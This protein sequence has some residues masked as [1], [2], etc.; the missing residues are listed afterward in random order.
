MN[1]QQLLALRWARYLAEF[2]ART[3]GITAASLLVATSS[4]GQASLAEQPV[5]RERNAVNPLA[6]TSGT[7]SPLGVADG[8][9]VEEN[10]LPKTL[11]SETMG[12][13]TRQDVGVNEIGSQIQPQLSTSAQDLL[14]LPS[15][16]LVNSLNHEAMVAPLMIGRQP[17]VAEPNSFFLGFGLTLPPPTALQGPARPVIVRPASNE[18]RGISGGIRFGF[19]NLGGNDQV[20]TLG[21]E[22]GES[23]L[24]FDLDFRQFLED[25]SGYAVNFANRRGVAPEF[26]G[27]SIDVDPPNGGDPWVHR[28]GG[29]IEYFRPLA[30]DWDGALGISY[31]RVS[32]R[33]DLFTSELVAQDELGNPLTVSDD[34]QDDLLTLNFAAAFDQR[35]DPLFP[36]A[37]SRLLFGMDQA[38]PFG[39]ANLFYT[40]LSANYT[41]FIPLNLF[42]LTAGPQTLVLNI[43][44]GTI[45][46]DTPPYEAFSLGGASSVRGYR[47]GAVGTGRSFIQTTAEYRFPIF[48][49]NAF[50]EE[51]DIGGTLFFDYATDLGSGAAVIGT[52]GVVRNK[53]GDGFG[54]GFGVRGRTPFG[55][56]RLEFGITDEGDTRVIFNIGDRF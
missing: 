16:S 37:G 6:E 18:A 52:P 39:D 28:F 10:V 44:G 9:T 41:Q 36:T 12:L 54:Y 1:T 15:L 2:L 53:P 19:L 46:G 20:L 29:G 34:G 4:W 22:G 51:I 8:M 30:R 24:G 3:T 27:G 25:E 56:V 7:D 14:A 55:P 49:F 35:D 5:T 42:G 38:I 23:A 32:V 31:Q 33:N 45:V 43:Q 47:G 40:R 13:L 17:E 48:S 26:T 50:Q 21:L 11:P